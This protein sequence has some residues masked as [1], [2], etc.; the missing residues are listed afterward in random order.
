VRRTFSP[1]RR[2]I[3]A[4]LFTLCAAGCAGEP[5]AARGP[6]AWPADVRAKLLDLSPAELPEPPDDPTNRYLDDPRT[7]ALGKKFFFETR[8]SGPLLDASNT[9]IPGTLG[10]VGDTGKVGCVS[11]HV[12]E[13]GFLDARSPR[14][15]ISLGA[16]WTHRRAPSLLDVGQVRLLMWDGRRDAAFNQP[17]TPIEDAFEMN[18]SR[19]FVAQQ[20][21]R[22]YREEYEAIFGAL[23]SLDAYEPLDA[24]EAGCTELPVDVAHATCPRPGHDDDEVTRVVVN[25]GKAIQAFT[26]QLRCGRSRFDRWMDGEATALSE[27]EQAGARLFVGKAGCAACHNGPFL[28]SQ[29]FHNVGLIPDFA[30]FID[31]FQDPGAAAG[32]AAMLDDPLG[33][34]GTFSDGYD[35]RRE[36]LSPDSPALLGAFRTPGLRCVSRR[37]SLFH[38]GQLRSLEDVVNFF[39]RG[40]HPAIPAPTGYLGTSEN[41][42]RDLTYEEQAAIVAF[43]RAV[44]GDGPDPA[45][46]APPDLP[47]DR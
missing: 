41:H 40:G 21:K 39:N 12:P 45:L 24:K 14:Q 46:V 6:A 7:A 2:S 20:V 47:K 18:S 15:Q 43:L 25:L 1:V 33:S 16:G 31:E 38:T 36:N 28:T 9:G 8:F 19:L 3:P 11:C 4:L 37:P 35:G 13:R 22:L 23:P 27:D 44:D 29:Q 30:L 32:I 42:P 17:F 10:N 26:R 34:D 5:D